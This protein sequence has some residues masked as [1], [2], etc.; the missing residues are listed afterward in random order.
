MVADSLTWMSS[1][2]LSSSDVDD[3][4]AAVTISVDQGTLLLSEA[5]STGSNDTCP[6]D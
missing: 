1:N 6:Q 2:A 3:I 4:L 5:S